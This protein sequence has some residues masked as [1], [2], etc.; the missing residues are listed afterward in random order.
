MFEIYTKPD[1]KY[2]QMAKELLTSRNHNYTEYTVPTP[3]SKEM[4]QKKVFEAGS[5]VE[6]RSVPQIFYNGQYIG[7]FENLVSFLNT[8]KL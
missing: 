7:G 8:T 5:D 4:L 6:V 1:C 3:V 2:C